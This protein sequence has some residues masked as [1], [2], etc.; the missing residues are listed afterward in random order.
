MQTRDNTAFFSKQHFSAATIEAGLQAE[1]WQ[2][3]P[4]SA[5]AGPA[6]EYRHRDFA[7]G[8]GFIA[9]Y[10]KDFCQSCNRLRV[11]AQGK[12][13]LCLFGGIAYDLRPWLSS[14]DQAGLQQHLYELMAE[15][16]EHH[17]LHDRKFGLIRD[18]SMIGG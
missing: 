14:G 9:P 13:H 17:F 10:S 6:R 8:I 7:G 11:T 1:G 12:M 18:L 5:H 15:K 3:V 4:R 2:L 16:P